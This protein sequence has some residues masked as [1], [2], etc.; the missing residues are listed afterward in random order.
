MR[1]LD[2]ITP[3]L[4]RKCIPLVHISVL[5]WK[6]DDRHENVYRWYTFPC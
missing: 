4:A 5:N 3:Q 2:D 6:R 1:P